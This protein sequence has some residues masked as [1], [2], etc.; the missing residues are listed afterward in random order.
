MLENLFNLIKEQGTDV[1]INNPVIPNNQNNAVIADATNSVATELQG[2]LAGGSLQ[3]VLSMFGNNKKGNNGVN[4]ML[5]NPIVSNIISS[6]THKLTNNHGIAEGQASGIAQNLIPNVISSLVSKTNNPSDS[7]FNINGIINALS[8]GG[9][10]TQ[11][12][13]DFDLQGIVGKFTN[14]N[15][16]TD[17]DGQVEISDIISKVTGGAQKQQA[18]GASGGFMDMI[19]GFMK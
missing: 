18:S 6:F 11:A 16:D 7:S 12:A 14:G 3:S 9:G 5:N 17:G 13:G 4:S 15:L 19:K 8:G 10:T 2:A 1:V